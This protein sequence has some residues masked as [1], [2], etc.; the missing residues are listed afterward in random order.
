[1]NKPTVCTDDMLTF[2]DIFV[3]NQGVLEIVRVLL[4]EFPGLMEH[5]AKKIYFYWVE[6]SH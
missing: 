6:Q 4:D 3:A 2:L 1:M 5:E